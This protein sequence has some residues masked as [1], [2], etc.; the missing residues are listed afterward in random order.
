MPA[1]RGARIRRL[2]GDTM[3]HV[4]GSPYPSWFDVND[5]PVNRVPD[6]PND[7][8][9]WDGSISGDSTT[10]AGDSPSRLNYAGKWALWG[11]PHAFAE[12]GHVMY[13][14][15]GSAATPSRIRK[16]PRSGGGISTYRQEISVS[17]NDQDV[18][19]CNSNGC[20]WTI[21]DDG[22]SSTINDIGLLPGGGH[23]VPHV[24]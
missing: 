16:L 20:A 9:G 6:Q 1:D 10:I 21:Q 2:S 24:L 15:E 7:I 23:R 12:S 3:Y 11:Q 22:I 8:F 18:F 17:P 14:A 19:V 5:R 4:A 13:V